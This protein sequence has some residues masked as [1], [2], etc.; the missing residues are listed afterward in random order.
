MGRTTNQ[1][2]FTLT[3]L[4]IVV[5]IIATLAAIAVPAFNT[6]RR[7]GYA[8]EGRA[9]TEALVTAEKTYRQRNG[10]F[11][12]PGSLTAAAA[13]TNLG[14]NIDESPDFT[15]E[16]SESGSTLTVTATG[17]E[18]SGAHGLEVRATYTP[19]GTTSY[20]VTDSEA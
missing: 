14:V 1:H 19:G 17:T 7:Q 18:E 8:T 13:M 10:D 4:L 20:A 16:I 12:A 2:G 6:Y 9:I 15:F 3:E 11:W 5:T